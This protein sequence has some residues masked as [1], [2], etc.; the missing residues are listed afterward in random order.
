MYMERLCP[1]NYVVR[2]FQTR[3]F[4]MALSFFSKHNVEVFVFFTQSTAVAS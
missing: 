3:T 4:D 2:P 1:Y